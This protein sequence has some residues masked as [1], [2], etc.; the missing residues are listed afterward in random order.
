MTKEIFTHCIIRFIVSVAYTLKI[1][2][3]LPSAVDMV[4]SVSDRS[5]DAKLQLDTGDVLP[6]IEEI[7][8]PEPPPPVVLMFKYLT[9]SN[10]FLFCFLTKK[11][12]KRSQ[13]E[14]NLYEQKN[15]RNTI[16]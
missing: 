13:Q 16:F 12:L 11:M 15:N 14:S 4:E 8:E 2:E 7:V 1:E 10:T 3:I 9:L 6:D 5:S